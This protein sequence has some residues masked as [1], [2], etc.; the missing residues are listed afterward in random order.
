MTTNRKLPA[1][2][3]GAEIWSAAHFSD[4]GHDWSTLT[5]GVSNGSSEAVVLSGVLAAASNPRIGPVLERVTR[6][7]L[8]FLEHL[9]ANLGI[10]AGRATR[11]AHLAY[12]LYLGIGE[13]RRA[14][15]HGDPV[16]QPLDAYLQ[17]AIDA[18][19]PPDPP[20]G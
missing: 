4:S 20:H 17:L 12:A 18:M 13:L 8:A 7:R 5:R 2:L 15:P 10:S 11:R 9:Y 6:T 16:G 19:L 14:D 3:S 1:D